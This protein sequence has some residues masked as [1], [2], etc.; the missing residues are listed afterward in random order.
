MASDDT[1]FVLPARRLLKNLCSAAKAFPQTLSLELDSVDTN[2][3]IGGGGFADIFL[4]RYKG[5]DIALKRLR[6]NRSEP[7]EM[8][9]FSKVCIMPFHYF[10]SQLNQPTEPI[11]GSSHLGLPQTSLRFTIFWSRRA[12]L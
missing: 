11:A 9:K 3:P 2:R 6:V 1:P 7:N 12:I 5:Q 8:L 4:G 10:Q